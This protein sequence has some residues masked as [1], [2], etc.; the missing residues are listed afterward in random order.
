MRIDYLSSSTLISDSA[1][2]VHVTSMVGAFRSL[3]H[4]ACLYG[5]KGSGSEQDVSAYYG[6]PADI[7]LVR[8][9]KEQDEKPSWIRVIQRFI[10]KLRVGGVPALCFGAGALQKKLNEDTDLVFARNMYWVY[11]LRKR[12]PF[13]FESHSPPANIFQRMIERILL[14]STN[15]KALIVISEKLADIYRHNYPHLQAPIIVAHDAANDPGEKVVAIDE[16]MQKPFKDIG[17]VGHLYKGRGIELIL[18]I[19]GLCPDLKFHIVGGQQALIDEFQK[20]GCPDN[21][22]FYGHQPPSELPEFYKKFDA[23]LA[24][25]QKKVAV[26]GNAGDTSAFMSPLKIFEYM[27]W[28]LPVLCSDLPVLREV[29]VDKSNALLLPPDSV[30]SWAEALKTLQKD[31]ELRRSLANRARQDFLDHYS[32][33]SRAKRILKEAGYEA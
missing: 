9:H 30:D 12:R 6:M 13:I 2:A 18:G 32:W 29:L 11:G 7:E 5:Y 26:H 23:V 8:Y 19:A 4:E 21:V 3:G 16:K 28:G 22:I 31:L 20:S 15:L 25:Y 33:L 24:P 10:P 27:S 14:K 17:Y 1:N